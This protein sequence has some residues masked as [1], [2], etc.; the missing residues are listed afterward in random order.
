[1]DSMKV[2]R[3]GVAMDHCYTTR[4]A[5]GI[6]GTLSLS[7]R[8]SRRVTS[9]LGGWN[10][11]DARLC[12]WRPSGIHSMH[13]GARAMLVREIMTQTVK[14]I[15]PD[16]SLREAA[17]LMAAEDCGVL[18]VAKDDRLVGMLTDRDITVRAVARSKD[19]DT[20]TVGEVRSRE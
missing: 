2:A 7:D 11:I 19:P 17:R 4:R 9:T 3:T 13:R 18:P 15:P 16:A 14:T 8:P 1:M 6:A 10:C 12:W 20:C 5:A